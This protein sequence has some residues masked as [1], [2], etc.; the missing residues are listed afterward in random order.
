M[1]SEEIIAGTERYLMNTYARQP[2]ALTRGAGCR[3]YDPEGREYIDFVSGVA[4][5]AL[6]HC[7]EEVTAAIN[8]QA[9]TLIHVSNLYHTE[10]QVQLAKILVEHSFADKVFF[11]NS[12]AE[13]NETAIKLTRQYAT[14]TYGS[15]RYEIIAMENSF[16]GRTMATIAA[17]GQA[18]F[19]TGIGPLLPG[20]LHIPFNDIDAAKHAVTA[21]TAG[22]LVEPIQGEG[23]VV[24]ADRQFLQAL[25]ELCDRSGSLLIFDEVQTGV[26]R[27]G[28]LFAYEHD[29]VIP[30]IMTL[31][32]GLGGGV[33]IGA[34]LA[35]EQ[36][37]RAFTPG[38]HGST[39]GGNP[40]V[41]SVARAVLQRL[42]EKDGLLDRC[43]EIGAYFVEKLYALK[44]TFACIQEIRG[45]GLLLG[46][47]LDIEGK[48]IVDIC[49]E[50]GILI[51]CTGGRVLRFIP[52]LTISRDDIDRLVDVL[53]VAFQQAMAEVVS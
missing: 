51:N 34:C 6:G 27:T 39:L 46:L 37:A 41:C 1:T 49:R 47:A 20:I 22:I 2:L 12:G 15:E 28:N 29:G 5:D 26:G 25:R 7:A 43:R 4:V 17:T 35:T 11:C 44:E 42:L 30:D 24:S 40:L 13:A 3:V 18:R 52:P 45:R 16:H 32:K 10:P 50:Q 33:P 36:V 14:Q 8:T 9:A 31:A 53:T 38:M 48:H 19:H 23:G 21:S